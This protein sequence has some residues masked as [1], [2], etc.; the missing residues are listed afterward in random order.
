MP[1]GAFRIEPLQ[2]GG[3][4]V[5][6][7]PDAVSDGEVAAELRAAWQELG[8]L[9][10]RNVSS[11]EEH[12]ALSSVFAEP[13]PHPVASTHDSE[14]PRVMT[15]GDGHGATYV[16]D[17]TQVRRGRLPWHRDAAYVTDIPQGAMLRMLVP[18]ERSGE[19]L[20]ADT[21]KAYDELPDH[22][23]E[24]VDGLEFRA[25]Q[26]AD[27]DLRTFPGTLWQSVRY[28]TEEE[29]PGNEPL[30][31]TW[32][33]ILA[34]SVAF[35]PVVHPA[36]VSHPDSGRRC[37]FFSPK[38]FNYFLGLSEEESDG[39]FAELVEHV[40]QERYVYTHHWSANDAVI[41][42]NWRMMHAAAGYDVDDH[43]LAQR[44]TLSG[45]LST[46]RLYEPGVAANS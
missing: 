26:D 4:V 18:S 44:T 5:D 19:T 25:H 43:R 24:R 20:F 23:R 17:G 14:D 3:E 11:L 41:W 13:K 12:V 8:V 1:Q 40:T 33:R 27:W 22:L 30:I 32:H 15:L 45:V 10:F 7:D 37:L 31:V 38:D 21:A 6:L 28:A 42:D 34:D 46:G 35:T 29:Y 36:V 16:Y 2:V 9:V 39:L